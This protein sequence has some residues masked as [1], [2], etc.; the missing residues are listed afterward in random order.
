MRWVDP[1][2]IDGTGNIFNGM[3]GVL[4]A[5]LHKLFIVRSNFLSSV[6]DRVL[7]DLCE[8]YWELCPFDENEMIVLKR[9]MIDEREVFIS[10]VILQVVRFSMFCIHSF[11]KKNIHSFYKNRVDIF[12]L[13]PHCSWSPAFLPSTKSFRSSSRM[14]RN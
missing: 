4:Y 5:T 10:E 12:S 6:V 3:D 2:H 8:E 1:T 11:Y 14:L 7:D 9:E 13:L